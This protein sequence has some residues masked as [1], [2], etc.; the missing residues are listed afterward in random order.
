MDN[1]SQEDDKAGEIGQ[2]PAEVFHHCQD[3]IFRAVLCDKVGRLEKRQVRMSQRFIHRYQ[4]FPFYAPF[5]FDR[6]Q[7]FVTFGDIGV[8]VE[9]HPEVLQC[10][11]EGQCHFFLPEGE[12]KGAAAYFYRCGIRVPAVEE[13]RLFTCSAGG[14][15]DIEYTAGNVIRHLH[16]CWFFF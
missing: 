16:G 8:G 14:G 6:Y 1:Q 3:S 13:E 9:F 15:F 2:Q 12:N 10:N 4:Y 11:R 7:A 5:G